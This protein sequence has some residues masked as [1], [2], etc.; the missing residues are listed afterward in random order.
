MK[1]FFFIYEFYFLS[2]SFFSIV[3]VYSYCSRVN[4][5]KFL[6]KTFVINI[7][8]IQKKKIIDLY[9][10]NIIMLLSLSI[11]SLKINHILWIAGCWWYAHE[12]DDSW[13]K[14]SQRIKDKE[15]QFTHVRGLDWVWVF[16]PFQVYTLSRT[17]LNYETVLQNIV[18]FL[19]L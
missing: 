1:L 15:E 13:A 19:Q 10:K 14:G 17:W 4:V 8:K 5:F 12:S 9:K 7:N 11:P 16:L 2:L 6:V 18:L 3:N